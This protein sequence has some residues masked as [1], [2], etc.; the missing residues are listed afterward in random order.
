MNISQ[1]VVRDVRA[2][3]SEHGI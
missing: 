3:F 2:S 1:D